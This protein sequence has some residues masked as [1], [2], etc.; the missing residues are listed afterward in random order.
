MVQTPGNTFGLDAGVLEETEDLVCQ[1]WAASIGILCLVEIRRES[2]KA[3]S[4]V[5]WTGVH[6]E[7]LDSD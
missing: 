7:S 4:I 6:L 3:A 2:I 5:S 1:L